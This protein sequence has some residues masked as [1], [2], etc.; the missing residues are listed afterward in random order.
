MVFGVWEIFGHTGY[1]RGGGG[2]DEAIDIMP[3][4]VLQ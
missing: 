4:G 1:G 2:V 3:N